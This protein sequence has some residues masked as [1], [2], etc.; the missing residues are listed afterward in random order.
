MNLTLLFFILNRLFTVEI[1]AHSAT[2]GRDRTVLAGLEYGT[3]VVR[4]RRVMFQGGIPELKQAILDRF[5][6]VSGVEE[7][8]PD[9]LIVHVKRAEFGGEFEEIEFESDIPDKAVVK[10][11][12]ETVC[13]MACECEKNL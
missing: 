6:D 11:V 3:R 12:V 1:M 4:Y 10:A 13:V 9:Q 7:L 8:E 5:I 2:F